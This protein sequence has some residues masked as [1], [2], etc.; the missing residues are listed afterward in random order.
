MKSFM[1]KVGL[2]NLLHDLF[3]DNPSYNEYLNRSHCCGVKLSEESH[4]DEARR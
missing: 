1:Q 4:G 2:L 3:H